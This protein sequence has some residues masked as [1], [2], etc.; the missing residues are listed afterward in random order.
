MMSR[1]TRDRILDAAWA[2]APS[3]PDFTM[4]EVAAKAGLSRQAVYLHFS[5]RAALV[6][7]MTV[8]LAPAPSSAPAEAP[9]ARAALSTLLARLATEYPDL[10]PVLQ[11]GGVL[12]SGL[13]LAQCRALVERFRDE[14]ALA[15]HLAPGTAADLLF[16]LTSPAL[17]HELVVERGWDS[18]RYRSHVSF[19]AIS[20]LTK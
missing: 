17:W 14:A 9:S 7:A 16:S 5:N 18:A 6:M 8:R 20:A 13:R 12:D 2:C 11:A 3:R 19:L 15:P 4:A 10:W 1:D